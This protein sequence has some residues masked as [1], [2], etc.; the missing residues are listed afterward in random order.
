MSV[1]LSPEKGEKKQK[2]NTTTLH[3][4]DVSTKE[5]TSTSSSNE[6]KSDVKSKGDMG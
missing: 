2:G 4:W 3:G 1:C 5:E 6:S